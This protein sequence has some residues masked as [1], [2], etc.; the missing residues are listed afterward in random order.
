MKLVS[1]K[2]P[3]Y[4]GYSDKSIATSF[5]LFRQGNLPP[6]L[7]GWILVV[8]LKQGLRAIYG[9]DL[10]AAWAL[11]WGA[12][13]ECARMLWYRLIYRLGYNPLGMGKPRL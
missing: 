13:G 4:L 12:V 7:V 3:E 1:I 5:R 10:R 11:L 8:S 6:E 9:S 2:H